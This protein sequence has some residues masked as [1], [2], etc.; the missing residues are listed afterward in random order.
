MRRAQ[1]SAAAVALRTGFA[2][3]ANFNELNDAVLAATGGATGFS[4]PNFF[5]VANDIHT[6]RFQMAPAGGEG[7]WSK[8]R[9]VGEVCG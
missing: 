2:S 6:P 1:T 8:E 9:I 7:D 3:G 5:N 4:V